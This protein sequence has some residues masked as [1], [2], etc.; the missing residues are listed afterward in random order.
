MDPEQRRRV[1][2]AHTSGPVD[3]AS[4]RLLPPP[5]VGTAAALAGPSAG[6]TFEDVD[7]RALR[8]VEW[9]EEEAA[10]VRTHDLSLFSREDVAGRDA[11]AD[12]GLYELLPRLHAD[13]AA[14]R[15]GCGGGPLWERT[16]G[17]CEQAAAA[18][19]AYYLLWSRTKAKGSAA[20][21]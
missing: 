11:F 2:V 7:A 3:A 19:Q 13:A 4:S 8:L 12:E 5:Q 9:A 6:P 10:Y 16:R 18:V 17:L 1:R 20:S 15:L 14:L 21:S